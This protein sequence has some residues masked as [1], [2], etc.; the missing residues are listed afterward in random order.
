MTA[1]TL[2]DVFVT[3]SWEDDSTH[4]DKVVQFTNYLRLN[5]FEAEMDRLVSQ[6]ETAID[7]RVMMHKAM[8]D[9]KKVVIILSQKYKLKATQFLG[10]V[11]EEYSLI[12]N[13]IKDNPNKYLL[14]SFGGEIK[15]IAPLFFKG[16]E[17]VNIS[18]IERDE[19]IQNV[20]FAKL[21]DEKILIFDAPKTTK[22]IIKKKY[23]NPK[24]E[25]EFAELKKK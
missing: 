14:V 17:I 13:D 24:K 12:M 20:I 5:G 2:K 8:T 23:P 16:R 21:Q 10:G 25:E 1:T 3:Y 19:D 6:N 7:F 9:Y 15:D 22:P 4:N 18:H 11:G